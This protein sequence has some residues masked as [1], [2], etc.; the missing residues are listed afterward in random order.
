MATYQ[1]KQ[2]AAGAPIPSSDDACSLLGVTA[3]YVTPTGGLASG[4][5]IEMGPIPP[6]YIPVD[7][8]VHTGILGTSVTLDAGILTGEF[9]TQPAVDRTMGSEFFASAQAAATAV[10]LR[11]TKSFAALSPGDIAAVPTGWGL[12]VGGAT[13]SAAIKIRA[14]MYFQPAP[15]GM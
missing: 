4:A 5:I 15:I 1:S 12:K 13:T 10:L 8:V 3:E 2:V 7:L 9:G 11:A 14:T 6:G